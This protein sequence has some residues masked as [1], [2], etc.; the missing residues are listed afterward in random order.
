MR[1]RTRG[2]TLIEIL[3]AVAIVG[4]VMAVAVLSLTLASDDRAVRDEARRFLALME[5][6]RD[7]AI[8]QMS[9]QW[10]DATDEQLSLI[11]SISDRDKRGQAKI[12]R[13]YNVMQ[14]DPERAR[15]LLQDEDIPDYMR[16]QIE[17]NFNQ[18]RR[19]Y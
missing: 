6:A 2:F 12:R 5:L 9:Y 3:V 15:E 11:D 1:S 18:Y 13:I 10:T 19:R 16:Q 4:I 7:D 8:M 17:A 14:T